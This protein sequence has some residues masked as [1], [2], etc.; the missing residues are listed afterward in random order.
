[1]AAETKPLAMCSDSDPWREDRV[2]LF[3]S[4]TRW[5]VCKFRIRAR[6]NELSGLSNGR[7]HESSGD[8]P[9]L[10]TVLSIAGNIFV[11]WRLIGNHLESIECHAEARGVLGAVGGGGRGGCLNSF[12]LLCHGERK[13]MLQNSV[14]LG[15]FCS[16][17]DSPMFRG[18]KQGFVCKIL[19][20]PCSD[21]SKSLDTS[22]S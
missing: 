16:K 14:A 20:F 6:S 8:R 18:P 21:F 15:D 22:C 2:S 12:G 13:G 1:M 19:Q 4:A 11:R 9:Q 17:A 3:S 7:A 5:R 10:I